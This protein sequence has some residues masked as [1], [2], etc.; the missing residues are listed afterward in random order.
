MILNE[1][2]NLLGFIIIGHNFKN[3][4]YTGNSILMANSLKDLL[5]KLVDENKKKVIIAF[6]TTECMIVSKRDNPK[7]QVTHWKCKNQAG[8][9][10]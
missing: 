4:S 6:K 1:L 5:N 7:M 2:E 8:V 3:I 9:E 10:I